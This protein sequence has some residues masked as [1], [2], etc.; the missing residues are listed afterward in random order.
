MAALLGG[1][2]IVP[3]RVTGGSP[4]AA[5]VLERLSNLASGS[6]HQRH[7][8]SRTEQV[9][10]RGRRVLPITAVA[11]GWRVVYL[12]PVS[13]KSTSSDDFLPALYRAGNELSADGQRAHIGANRR[14]LLLLLVG[15]LVAAASPAADLLRGED[16]DSHALAYHVKQG[17]AV[18]AAFLFSGGLWLSALLRN[19][20]KASSWYDGRAIAESAKSMAWKYMM[21]AEPYGAALSSEESN[22]L[23][24]SD[25][26]K[27]LAEAGTHALLSS[28]AAG[29]QISE[30]M[31]EVRHLDV[32]ERL[33]VYLSDRVTDQREWYAR[34]AKDH[35]TS[36]RRWFTIAISTNAVAL[37]I[38]I[39]GVLWLPASGVVGV[40]TTA[41]SCCVAWMQLQRYPDLAHSYSFTSHEIGLL[42]PRAAGVHTDEALAR[43]VADCETAFSR[44]H[45]MWRA[46]R[47]IAEG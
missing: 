38:S 1:E 7:D 47:E 44:E 34:R 2:K 12:W 16:A 9:L 3:A 15:S 26:R 42:A 28:S 25:L 29:D 45:T 18:L 22:T 33:E 31:V 37:A 40:T 24:C 32:L 21:K 14:L 30:R 41:A 27:L 10:G 11:F 5:E 23:F 4:S 8:A 6:T 19:A 43:F 39:C 17:L 20:K 46:R 36:A 13:L 35:A